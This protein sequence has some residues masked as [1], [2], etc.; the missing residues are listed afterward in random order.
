MKKT[1]LL[2]LMMASMMLSAQNTIYVSTSGLDT[3]DGLSAGTPVK[4]FSKAISMVNT[5]TTDVVLA[6]GTYLETA[7]ATL[8]AAGSTLVIRGEN[9]KTTIIQQTSAATRIFVNGAAHRA[10]NNSLTI[11]DVT[12]KGG[13]FTNGGGPA[14]NY[15]ETSGFTNDLTL[16]R[17]IFEGNTST[18]SGTVQQNGGALTFVGNKLNVNNCYFKNNAVVVGATGTSGN[19]FITT[20]GAI[21]LVNAKANATVT[22]T[23]YHNGLFVTISNTTF[24]GNSA[25]TKGGAIS[26][27]NSNPKSADALPSS[28]SLT[29][30]TFLNNKVT[31]NPLTNGLADVVTGSAFSAA[32]TTVGANPRFDFSF[33]NC[34]FSGNKG[35]GVDGSGSI[36]ESSATIDIDGKNWNKAIMVNNI[37]KSTPTANCGAALMINYKESGKLQGSNNFVESI[38]TDSIAGPAFS[39]DLVLHKNVIGAMPN[40]NLNTTLTDNST[41]SVFAVPY[42]EITTGSSAIDAGTNGFGD[43][44]IVSN[45]DAR[46]FVVGGLSKDCGAY[47]F[48]GTAGF[49]QTKQNNA[50]SIYPNPTLSTIYIDSNDVQ[51]VDIYSISGKKLQSVSNAQNTINVADLESGLYL[52]NIKTAGN[53]YMQTFIKK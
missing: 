51:K 24:E 11:K 52:I 31:K 20:G 37:I 17:V 8:N 1:I 27:E 36:N 34:T 47:E 21:Y 12:L 23:V 32:T 43:P 38:F 2:S 46:G 25:V 30:C 13:S 26:V 29:N 40:I 7:V 16:E 18:T 28:V 14:V 49:F 3:N 41:A 42:L 10:S 50:L 45:S 6:A 15:Q 5:T 35:G 39:T 33:V 4:T 53:T 48:G 44:N 22:P 19:G 9:A